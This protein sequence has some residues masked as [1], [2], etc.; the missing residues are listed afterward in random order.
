MSPVH[1]PDLIRKSALRYRMTCCIFPI[2]SGETP[3]GTD[4]IEEKW[5]EFGKS[6][7]GYCW[8]NR[9]GRTF[10]AECAGGRFAQTL[11]FAHNPSKDK[12]RG[13][14]IYGRPSHIIDAS[15]YWISIILLAFSTFAL[16]I[17]GILTFRTPFSTL[18]L[19]FSVSASSGR[20]IVCW[21]LL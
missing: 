20:S 15:F 14:A 17:F 6:L 7:S 11:G 5:R 2:S 12:E 1:F 18:A 13:T 8:R 9:A 3:F 19:I 21:N 16:L 10:A 4:D